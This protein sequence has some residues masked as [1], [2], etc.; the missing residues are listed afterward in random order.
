MKICLFLQRSY[1]YT[2]HALACILKEKYGVTEFCAYVG[3][4]RIHDF[5]KSQKDVHYS[6]LL[7][8]EDVHNRYRDEKLD[9]EYLRSLEKEYGIPNLWP[10]LCVD[11]E[12]TGNQAKREY[13]YNTP[14]Y[15]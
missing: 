3:L 11:R 10:Y 2:G 7:L 5:L 12:I 1:A 9:M 8:D 4:R 6:A 15:T 14:R 13:P